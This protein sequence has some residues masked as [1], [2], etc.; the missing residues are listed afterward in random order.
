M[1]AALKNAASLSS[2]PLIAYA[3]APTRTDFGEEGQTKG[4]LVVD[5]D[6]AGTRMEFVETPARRFVTIDGGQPFIDHDE[7]AMYARTRSFVSS[8]WAPSRTGSSWRAALEDAGAFEVTEI[9]RRPVGRARGGRRAVREPD[10]RGGA[11]AYFADEPDAAVLV[12]RGRELLAE[13][14]P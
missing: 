8:T 2:D 14:G 11:A 1:N 3:G 7:L 6:E 9:R 12:E 5:V 10:G 4:Y 13:V